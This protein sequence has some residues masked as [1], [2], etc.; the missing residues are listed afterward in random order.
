MASSFDQPTVSKKRTIED[1]ERERQEAN[2]VVREVKRRRV[3]VDEAI[4]LTENNPETW[5]SQE[6]DDLFHALKDKIKPTTELE[7]SVQ[8][9]QTL[10]RNMQL[11]ADSTYGEG[12]EGREVGAA[13]LD[14]M[15]R[16]NSPNVERCV[17][18]RHLE[19]T[20]KSKPTAVHQQSK[21]SSGL[22]RFRLIQPTPYTRRSSPK[23]TFPAAGVPVD[24]GVSSHQPTQKR[25]AKSDCSAPK[26][27]LGDDPQEQVTIVSDPKSSLDQT[28]CQRYDNPVAVTGGQ[29]SHVPSF[30][31]LTSSQGPVSGCLPQQDQ[32][33]ARSSRVHR[34]SHHDI[35]AEK[36]DAQNRTPNLERLPSVCPAEIARKS[37]YSQA[38]T[39]ERHKQDCQKMLEEQD[40]VLELVVLGETLDWMSP[41]KIEQR[42]R[43]AWIARA[44]QYEREVTSQ[45]GIKMSG[46]Q[47]QSTSK[48]DMI[49]RQGSLIRQIFLRDHP[50]PLN[51]N[52]QDLRE[53][54]QRMIA[55]IT[56]CQ[57][58]ILGSWTTEW[59]QKKRETYLLDSDGGYLADPT[60]PIEA[61]QTKNPLKGATETKPVQP[62][63]K[64]KSH[65]V[66][67]QDVAGLQQD[68]AIFSGEAQGI[69]P[70]SA[71]PVKTDHFRCGS[72]D[73]GRK[74]R[75]TEMSPLSQSVDRTQ[76]PQMQGGLEQARAKGA[77][78][79]SE[80]WFRQSA[81]LAPLPSSQH[82]NHDPHPLATLSQPVRYSSKPCPTQ[83]LGTSYHQQT[84]LGLPKPAPSNSGS[85][86]HSPNKKR[87]RKRLRMFVNMPETNQ[88]LSARAQVND[89]ELLRSFP[90]HLCLPEVMS[91][92]V[93]D[94]GSRSGGWPVKRMV[95]VLEQHVN[96][97]DFVG[98]TR[99]KR[100]AN[101]T[102]WVTMMRD[103]CNFKRRK[104][105]GI[106]PKKVVERTTSP[107]ASQ[108]PAVPAALPFAGNPF[109]AALNTPVQSMHQTAHFA[110]PALPAG[111]NGTHYQMTQNIIDP[112][113]RSNEFHVLAS[114]QQGP[115]QS[116]FPTSIRKEELEAAEESAEDDVEGFFNF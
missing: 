15:Q 11:V 101:L 116:S 87:G 76:P 22:S 79:G 93:R 62:S 54:R 53:F 75:K 81:T 10:Q 73:I 39:A 37:N 47:F 112:T 41:T 18:L 84:S 13:E 65:L 50:L 80:D 43:E 16:A 70:Q 52:S 30:T 48:T 1:V 72:P 45:L 51:A 35:A 77:R 33:S 86:T 102:A 85:T 94:A 17:E 97:K 4:S 66:G 42:K 104:D 108:T 106:I 24:K 89:K 82:A 74:R 21:V 107:Q 58:S 55:T 46:C 91:R 111:T 40:R 25:E 57:L 26:Q 95:G 19:T 67:G 9:E 12:E 90:E 29:L 56:T 100:R 23:P 114:Q 105:A 8:E 113:L 27:A 83:A 31:E 109:Q 36:Q 34:F 71:E 92:F 68:S 110:Y 60:L 7:L 14:T 2:H 44:R 64:R 115:S 96:V 61:L 59:E 32:H 38:S 6:L 78:F 3:D 98:I 63:L 88:P 28:T 103:A 49:L 99:E 5:S 69:I 20:T